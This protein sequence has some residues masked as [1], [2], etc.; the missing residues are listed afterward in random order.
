[1]DLHKI[2]M[3]V[4]LKDL[5]FKLQAFLVNASAAIL[6]KFFKSFFNGL[7]ILRNKQSCGYLYTILGESGK[8]YCGLRL[9]SCPCCNGVCEPNGCNCSACAQLD[10]EE[11]ASPEGARKRFQSSQQIIN[12]WAW[13]RS[14]GQFI[15]VLLS[16]I[17]LMSIGQFVYVLLN[18]ILF[19]SIHFN[20]S[21]LCL[22][23]Q[24]IQF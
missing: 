22:Q 2:I 6:V 4:L 5:F 21:Y 16:I 23:F 13:K 20:I 19:M 1:M 3:L 10:A 9:L 24:V 12:M 8:Y 18:I 7:E 14:I 17:L 11:K 15:Y